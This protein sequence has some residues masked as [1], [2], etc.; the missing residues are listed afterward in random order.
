MLILEDHT[1]LQ[2]SSG[3]MRV[4]WFRPNTLPQHP[5]ARFPGVAVFTEIYQVTGPVE[6]FCRQIASLGYLVGCPESYHEFEVPGTVIPYD[7]EGT[8]RG[9]RYKTE[10]TLA[11][12]DEDAT[13]L[14]DAMTS[15]PNC[16]GRIGATG[17]CLGGH[18]A[19][20]C[21][22]D[23]R[24]SAS[25][26][27]FATDIHSETLGR[28]KASDSLARCTEI[29]GETLLI[30]GKRDTHIPFDG[31][32]KIHKALSDGGVHFSWYEQADA[33]HAFI[34][35]ELSKGRYDPA[36]ASH[37]FEML[38]ELFFR[39]LHV[40]YGAPVSA[41]KAAPEHKKFMSAAHA[42]AKTTATA[43]QSLTAREEVLALYRDL[44]RAARKWPNQSQRRLNVQPH[45]T[46]RLR[47]EFVR[48]D[49]DSGKTLAERLA[50]GRSELAALN[51]MLQGTSEAQYPLQE[52]GPIRAFLPP[53]RTYSLLDEP[54]QESM[55]NKNMGPWSF[56]GA[57]LAGRITREVDR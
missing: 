35:D 42:F 9:N 8:D 39:K 57:Y 26:C 47:S 5:S 25:V 38:K 3:P 56:I 27:Y 20:R 45:I 17:M 19:F 16:T 12:Y 37:C 4:H 43:A 11:A 50:H 6:R 10:K 30:F 23:S 1:D 33:Q 13:L 34:R 41:P 40:E 53:A 28:G 14:L 18:L 22:F 51:R 52:N 29:A 44:M 49:A 46:A 7:V 32:A 2:T 55:S 48:S 24:V 21:A 31:R 54:A 36:I 15:H